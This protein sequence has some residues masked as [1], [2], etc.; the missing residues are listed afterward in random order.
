[1]KKLI[2]ACCV[3]FV[4]GG[5]LAA[6]GWAAGGELYASYYSGAFHSLRETLHI[7]HWREWW[8]EDGVRHSGFFRDALDEIQDEVRGHIDDALD[9]VRPDSDAHASDT[10]YSVYYDHRGV[11]LERFDLDISGTGSVIITEGDDFTVSGGTL[12]DE[13]LSDYRSL[14][15]SLSCRTGEQIVVTLASD[16]S[17]SFSLHA[18]DC[19][20]DL[21]APIS[22]NT[23]N[24]ELVSGTISCDSLHAAQ[25]ATFSV[26][27]GSFFSTSVS[28]P[29]L[30]I[31]V[32]SGGFST[33]LHAEK[34]KY[35][36]QAISSGGSIYID[37]ME[38]TGPVSSV[39]RTS[40]PG[41]PL[42]L[43]RTESGTI[44]LLI[45]RPLVR[46]EWG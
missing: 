19:M 40:K 7:P 46:S 26:G 23:I 35:G 1:M 44:D 16:P 33:T 8:D 5:G 2:L 29:K 36:Y 24:I 15:L 28:A 10:V 3:L 12:L 11:I 27:A 13:G 32:G 34:E 43:L 18:D 9:E 21:Q 41:E 17:E 45:E 30:N 31:A 42:F 4:L 6:G 25:S 39:Y 20:I 38:I 37:G 14:H 22:S